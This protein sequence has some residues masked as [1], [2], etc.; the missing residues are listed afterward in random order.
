MPEGPSQVHHPGYTTTPGTVMTEHAVRHGI[1]TCAMG[2]K[3]G[4]RN[5]QTDPFEPFEPTIWLLALL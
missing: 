2:S 3:W 4:V 1:G 5:S